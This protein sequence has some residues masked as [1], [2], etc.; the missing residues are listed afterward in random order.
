MSLFLKE[1]VFHGVTGESL[2]DLPKRK[3]EEIRDRV[4]AGI[5]Q[6]IIAPLPYRLVDLQTT[7]H[8]LNNL[9]LTSHW[10]YSI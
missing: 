8:A 10:I 5:R 7:H 4:E 2:L 9:R 1:T 3:K 6:G